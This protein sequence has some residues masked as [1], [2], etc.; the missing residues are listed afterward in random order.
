MICS[1][2]AGKQ[3]GVELGRA[4]CLRIRGRLIAAEQLPPERIL[5]DRGEPR[6]SPCRRECMCATGHPETVSGA[7]EGKLWRI[8]TSLTIIA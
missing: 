2:N 7:I 3:L 1:K 6:A 5:V 8:E 4:G